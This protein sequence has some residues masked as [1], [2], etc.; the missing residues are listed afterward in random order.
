MYGTNDLDRDRKILMSKMYRPVG[1]SSFNGEY[2]DD[3]DVKAQAKRVGAT[4]VLVNS[5]YTNTQTTTS[6]LF[7][8]SSSTTQHSGSVYGGGVYGRY[9]GTSTT[10]GRT[11][12]PITTQQ[13][14]YD[15][16]AVFFVKSTNK[17]RVGVFLN[18]LSDR[19]R[20]TLERNTGA[21]I[22]A[23]A[24]ESPAFYANLL[25]GDVLIKV[26]D[27]NVKNEKHAVDLMRQLGPSEDTTM[28][29]IIRNGKE[30]SITIKL[31]KN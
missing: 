21:L 29:T 1:Y 12:V 24:E 9:S 14:R 27:S 4:V 13:M 15:Q 2:E 31:D 28:F 16:A 19:Q 20:Q 6:P 26:N 10:Y 5:E 30:Q 25:P 8:P 18:N 22:E 17:L 7:L 11:V 23:V 3:N